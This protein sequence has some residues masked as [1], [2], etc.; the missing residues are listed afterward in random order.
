MNDSPQKTALIVGGSS[1]IG[2]AVARL[3]LQQGVRVVIIG[4]NTEKLRATQLD[5]SALGMVETWAADITSLEQLTALVQRIET[6]LPAIHYLVNAAGIFSPKPFLEHTIADYVAYSSTNRGLFFVTQQVVKSMMNV[7]GGVIVNV[8]S[9][10]GQQ[11]VSLTPSS[12]YSMA[13]AALHQLTK[14]LALELAPMA[15]RVNA[16]SPGVVET[17]IYEAFMEP[18]AVHANLQGLNTFHPIGRI[19]QPDDVA[20]VIDFLL[21]DKA[22][23]VTGA[24]WDVDGGV[25]AGRN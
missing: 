13:K 12:A 21:S 20:S 19:G 25:M 8:G 2:K 5:L 7:G 9:M 14:H 4:R 18:T 15:I 11:A 10:W 16:V 24:I 1:G 17:P 22:G 23:W 6:E 3:L